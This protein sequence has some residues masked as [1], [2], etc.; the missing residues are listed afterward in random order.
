MTPEE[1]DRLTL[2]EEGVREVR[3]D[4]KEIKDILMALDRRM[5]HLEQVAAT[6]NGALRTSLYIGGIIGWVIGLAVAV[7]SLIK[8]H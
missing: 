7:I 4:I 8:G 6:G 1:R 5:T 3:G 2:S